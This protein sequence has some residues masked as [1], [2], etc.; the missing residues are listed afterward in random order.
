MDQSRRGQ[1]G[2]VGEFSFERNGT[3]IGI[4]LTWQTAKPFA[5][6]AASATAA[7]LLQRFGFAQNGNRTN[8]MVQLFTDDF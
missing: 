1:F 8:V 4:V 7:A 5:R 6:A 2:F 3:R